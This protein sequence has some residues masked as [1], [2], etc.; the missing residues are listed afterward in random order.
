MYDPSLGRWHSLDPHLEN[1]YS[2][3]PYNYVANNPIALMDPNGMD[4]YED[5]SGSVMW[6]KGSEN[7][8]GYKNLGAEYTQKLS[9]GNTIKYNQNKAIEMTEYVLSTKDFSSQMKADG[10]GKKDGIEGDCGYQSKE[11]SKESGASPMDNMT[12]G[13]STGEESGTSNENYKVVATK[14]AQKG[15]DYIDS[16]INQGKSAVVGVDRE[17]GNT[18]NGG[19]TDHFVSISSRTTNLVTG[20]KTYNFFDPGTRFKA[21]GTNKDNTFSVKAGLLVGK[22]FYSGKTYTV[23]HVRYNN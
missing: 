4:W 3:T 11:M 5:K 9:D 16:Q 7:V 20:S 15:I 8:E 14:D 17:Y 2:W 19:T 23:S 12:N 13:V 21:S 6:Q 18:R 1:Y 10:S 22:T